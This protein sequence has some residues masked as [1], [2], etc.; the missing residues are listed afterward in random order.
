MLQWLFEN[1]ESMSMILCRH[2]AVNCSISIILL[3]TWKLRITIRRLPAKLNKTI[4]QAHPH[5]HT[6]QEVNNVDALG[7]T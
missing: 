4:P 3:L 1:D 5:P 6:D 7:R 2:Q